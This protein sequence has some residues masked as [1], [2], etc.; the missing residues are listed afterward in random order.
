MLAYESMREGEYPPYLMLSNPTNFTSNQINTDEY[1]IRK[2][3]FNDKLLRLSDFY[4]FKKVSILIGGSTAFGVGAS[5]DSKTISSL[6]HK[7]TGDAWINLG[8]RGAVS[9]QEYICLIQHITKFKGVKELFFCSGINDIY[10]NLSD[11]DNTK[12]DKRFQFQNDLFSTCSARR[13]T[14][15]YLKSLFSRE[16]VNDM[17]ENRE[18]DKIITGFSI[19]K[20]IDLIKEQYK[21][22]FILYKALASYFNCKVTF[23]L[24]PFF[25]TSKKIG[26]GREKI[27]IKRSETNQKDTDWV[28]VR[29]RITSNLNTISHFLNEISEINNF[30]FINFNFF[31]SDDIEFFCDSVHLTNSGYSRIAET[32]YDLVC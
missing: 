2:T 3:V 25:H 8:I 32:Y 6:L 5:S 4:D 21:R 7:K 18:K 30:N 20:S 28:Q 9:F 27:A 14:Y 11:S 23:G 16:T 13:I 22:N 19:Q 12:Y 26:S 31:F 10:R 1:G 17:I 24:Q 29:E 15:L